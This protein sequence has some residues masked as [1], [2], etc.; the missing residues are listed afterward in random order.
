MIPETNMTKEN[1]RLGSLSSR[2]IVAGGLLGVV[3][4]SAAAV[5]AWSSHTQ[6]RFFLA[7]LNN[8]MFFLSLALGGLFI[9]LLEHLV[10]A[11][12][13]VVTRR[14]GE[15]VVASLPWLAMLFIPILFGL[16]YLYPWVHPQTQ[17]DEHLR[18]LLDWKQ[19]YLNIPFFAVRTVIY[20]AVWL[21]LGWYYLRLSMRQDAQTSLD[22]S[23]KV[24]LKMER[25]APVAMILFAITITFAAF[26]WLMSRDPFWYSTV[27][28]VY[29]FAGC[30][31]SAF[32]LISLM[33]ILLQTSGRLTESITCHHIQDLTK[34]TFG[35]TIFWAYIAFSQ[36]ML[37]WYGNIPEETEWF[38]RR[39]SGQWAYVSLLL[40][41]GHF[42]VPFIALISR[43]SKQIPALIAAVCVWI[44]IM[45][46]VDLYWLTMPE[47]F[48]NTVS[49]NWLDLLTFLGIGGITT[50]GATWWQR[51]QPLVPVGDPR[52]GASLMFENA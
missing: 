12:W 11:G 35:F 5:I 16:G 41:V 18:H 44:L 8:F 23:V 43:R 26:D 28:G 40:I 3:S 13:S 9:I 25:M 39:Q 4:L 20:F 34:Y 22:G 45:H 48:K 31:V 49:L 33:T 17:T 7:Y 37:I 6:E 10:R 14:I 50:A 2:L 27:Y 30:V 36:Y 38:L 15:W 42:F 1:I 21:A 19:P 46:W 24:T 47:T 32:A 51:S 29:Y 52:L